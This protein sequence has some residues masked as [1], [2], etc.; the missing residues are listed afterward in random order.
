[1][2]NQ[3][4]VQELK[5]LID[6]DEAMLIDVR[7][8]AEHSAENIKQATL[9]PLSQICMDKLPNASG[10]TLVI[11]CKSGMRSM[12]ACT[13]LL[14]ENSDLVV[15]NLEGG[16]MAWQQ[17][18]LPVQS[19]GKKI[20]PLDRQVQLTIG[21]FLL[22]GALFTYF[23]SPAFILISAFISIGLIF[24]ALSGTCGLQMILAKMPWN[25]ST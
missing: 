18:N 1:M 12:S 4:S 16:I 25:Q 23:F 2:I 6:N 17:A 22:I 20:L 11:H 21:I 10:K 7:E 13:K 15:H 5:K 14:S 3:I 19:S 9:I 24:A 8:P